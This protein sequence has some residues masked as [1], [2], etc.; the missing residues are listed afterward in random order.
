[1]VACCILVLDTVL[2]GLGLNVDARLLGAWGTQQVH[3]EAEHF[4]LL[5][6]SPACSKGEAVPARATSNSAGNGGRDGQGA[7]IIMLA[8]KPSG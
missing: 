2:A 6:S 5:S 3:L 7:A 4:L 8:G 1:M